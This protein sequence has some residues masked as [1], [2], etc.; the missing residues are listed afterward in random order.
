MTEKHGMPILSTAETLAWIQRQA[1][2]GHLCS[3]FGTV[4]KA[5]AQHL[6]DTKYPNRPLSRINTGKIKRALVDGAFMLNGE[7]FILNEQG[8]MLDGQNRCTAI[9]ETDSEAQVVLIAGIKSEA[10]KTMDLGTKRTAAHILAMSGEKDYITLGG[11]ARMHWR[12]MHDHMTAATMQL[13]DYEVLDY[14]NDHPN[15]R[16]ALPWGQLTRRLFPKGVGAALFYAFAEKNVSMAKDLYSTL[17]SGENLTK[18]DTIYWMRELCL[19]RRDL[20]QAKARTTPEHHTASLIKTWRSLCAK[21]PVRTRTALLWRSAD[22]EEFP[23]IP[24]YEYGHVGS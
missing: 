24:G 17:A 4:N 21:R 2:S 22:G 8:Q 20:R 5:V 18:N 16:N 12:L 23:H 9:I 13:A 11:A 10:F 6:L 14:L 1:S 19:Y 3:C 7:P 15:L